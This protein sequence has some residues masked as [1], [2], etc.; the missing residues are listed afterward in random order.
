VAAC[1]SGKLQRPHVYGTALSTYHGVCT[2][3]R[4]QTI[5]ISGESGA[6][7]TETTKFAMQLLA[8]AGESGTPGAKQSIEQQVLESNPLLEAFGNARTL[9]NDNSSRFGKF[10]QLQFKAQAGTLGLGKDGSLDV[11][12]MGARLCGARIQTY[13]LEGVRITDQQEGERNFHIFYQLCAAASGYPDLKSSTYEFPQLLNPQ[14]HFTE[15]NYT[16]TVSMPGLA[17]HSGFH[18][19]TRSS[20]FALDDVDDLEDFEKT[21]KA[22]QNV[23]LKMEEQ[24]A[25]IAAVTAVLHLGNLKFEAPPENSEGSMVTQRAWKQSMHHCCKATGVEPEELQKALC[26]KTIKTVEGNVQ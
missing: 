14:K 11:E 16:A 8:V 13:L 6:G 25:V 7:K 9:R 1:L 15:K 3:Q 2:E 10:I 22:M 23:G 21:V 5:L 12:K 17:D 20:C 18:Y 4:S 24:Q 19:L 26:M